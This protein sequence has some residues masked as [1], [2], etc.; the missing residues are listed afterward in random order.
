MNS[1]LL[2]MR[3]RDA[4]KAAEESFA[5]GGFADACVVVCLVFIL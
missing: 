4:M 2:N 1:A 5:P 3:L